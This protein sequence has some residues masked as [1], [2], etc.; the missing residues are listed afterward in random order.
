MRVVLSCFSLVLGLGLT[1]SA[2]QPAATDPA[3]SP[4]QPPPT[5]QQSAPTAANT[6]TRNVSL[7]VLDGVVLDKQGNVVTDLKR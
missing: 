7:V 6:I 1:A 5:T 3:A 2:Q 4:G